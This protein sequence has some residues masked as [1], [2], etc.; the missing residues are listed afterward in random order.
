MRPLFLRL[1]PALLLLL[2][3]PATVRAQDA[4]TPDAPPPPSKAPAPTEEV[5]HEGQ[6]LKV[7][8]NLVNI[9]FSAR[10]NHG[11]LAGLRKD[12]CSLM[13]DKTPQ[14]IKNLTQEKN[15]PLTIGILLDTS[16]SQTNVLPLEQESGATFLKDVL[17]PKD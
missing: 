13:E 16:G 1:L 15:L 2:S 9:Y 7:N 3:A 6:T 4:P 11:F 17:T 12:E 8:V 10:D 14:T 5:L